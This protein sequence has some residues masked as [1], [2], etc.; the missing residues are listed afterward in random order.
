MPS[1]LVLTFSTGVSLAEWERTGLLRREW[2]LYERLSSSYNSIVLLT[3][4]GPTDREIVSRLPVAGSCRAQVLC[5]EREADDVPGF[6]A[7]MPAHV[8]ELVGRADRVVVKTNQMQGG[9]VAVAIMSALRERGVRAGLVARGGYL[10]SRN[11][12]RVLGMDSAEAI[13][14]GAREGELCRAAGAVVVTTAEIAEDLCWRYGVPTERARVIPNYVL[15]EGAAAVGT[16]RP[17]LVLFAGRLSKEK[18][19]DALIEAMAE[20]NGRVARVELEV[21]GDGPEEGALRKLA[22][23]RGVEVNFMGRLPHKQLLERM[24]SCAVYAQLSA[25]EGHPKTVLE[26]MGA[27]AAVVVADSPGLRDVVTDSVTGVIVRGDDL[28]QSAASAI[29]SLL[30]SPTRQER[31][32]ASAA[33]WVQARLSLDV[34]VPLELAAHD[35]AIAAATGGELGVASLPPPPPPLPAVRWEPALLNVEPGEAVDAWGKS[36][37]GYSRR[38]EARARAKFL[39]GL[40][41][42]LYEMQGEAAVAAEGGLHPK[43]RLM[44]Y[45]DFFVERIGSGERVIDLGCGVG[46]LAASIADRSGAEVTGMDWLQKSLDKAAVV[47]MERGVAERVHWVLGD[48]TSERAPGEF[49]VVVLSNVLEHIAARAER[50]RMW[51]EWYLGKAGRVLIRVPAFDRE[52]RAPYKKE[53]GVEWRLDPTHETEYTEGQLREEVGA[54]GLRVTELIVRWGEYWAVTERA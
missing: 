44:R 1:A 26:A 53:L 7:G 49:E 13:E 2:A 14:A 3:Y 43:H 50:L 15:I 6:L 48:I 45:H 40:D 30:Q 46:A 28:V 10:W 25:Y 42:P 33:E 47:A 29:G 17:D 52:W 39:L 37:R 35:C 32:G 8:A 54:A 21:V 12:A 16:R 36:L 23:R 4:G 20:V 22:A 31:L 11:V 19:V 41:E 34:I 24:R 27:G 9:E 38:L 51:R 18:R 5:R